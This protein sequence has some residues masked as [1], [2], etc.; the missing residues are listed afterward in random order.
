MSAV[1]REVYDMK[2]DIYRTFFKS[3][4][5]LLEVIEFL[6]DATMIID[7]EG[8]VVMWN[9]AME[10]LTGVKSAQITGKGNYEHSIPFYG[11]RRPTL[12]DIALKSYPEIEKTYISLRRNRDTLYGEIRVPGFRDGGTYLWGI[13][14]PLYSSS[15]EIIGAIESI[16]DITG[17]KESHA[18]IARQDEELLKADEMLKLSEEKFSKAFRSSPMIISIST[19]AD[20]RYI[21]VSDSFYEETGYSRDEVIGH[22]AF[23]INI[24]VDLS[25][26]DRI[27]SEM[28]EKGRVRELEIRFRSKDGGIRTKLFSAEIISLG[29]VPCLLAVNA[30]ITERK[31]AME[32][33]EKQKLELEAVNSELTRTIRSMEETHIRLMETQR[34]LV[35]SN[36]RL[37]FSE[38]KFSKTVH[39]GPVIITLSRLAD[40][41]Y[42][43]VSEYFLKLTGYSRD[44]VVGHSSLDLNIWDDIA[45]RELVIEH[46]RRDGVVKEVD[47][48][49][50]AKDGRVFI[51]RYS[52]EIVSIAGEP[53]L[54][55]VAV[56][57]TERLKAEKEKAAVEEQLL[58]SQKMETVGRLAGGI[59]HDFN[60]LLT[61]IMGHV[62]LS[63]MKIG[64]E[65]PLRE[66]LEVI[67]RASET[68]ADLTKRILAFSRKQVIEPKLI[69][70]DE[71]IDHMEMLL[72]RLIG[73]NVTLET[74][75]GAKMADIMADP[76]HMEQVLVNLA[77]N[78]RDAMPGG[79]RLTLE[80]ANV[81]L[82][83]HYCRKHP[84]ALPGEYV[85]LSV[86]DTGTGMSEEVKKHLFEP[87]F[88][89]KP[90][91]QGT[92]LGL[93]MV[94]GVV[95]QN[96]GTIEVYSVEGKG[97]SFKMY[98][99][100]AGTADGAEAG[101]CGEESC[102]T[103]NET[104]L[105]VEDNPMVLGFAENVLEQ[106]GYRVFSAVRGE[107]M[108]A[109]DDSVINS[110]DI[111]IT[112]VILPGINGSDLAEEIKKRNPGIRVLY[113]SGYTEDFAVK[114]EIR[115]NGME[116]IGK[117]YS[118]HTL[119]RRI[120]DMLG[121]G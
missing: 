100:L 1:M 33:I 7:T 56:D 18:R 74:V 80:T 22:T 43:E 94:Y 69:N 57:I 13:A 20:G 61:A 88:T 2:K 97:T 81:H 59:A 42:V 66:H 113:T 96:G 109:M 71:V 27:L 95:R 4:D 24:W 101:S 9:H 25:D 55:S 102:L 46:L 93:S 3:E 52:A 11:E 31:K 32:I 89:T 49:F 119:L 48:R 58:Q 108:L 90:R 40:G 112:D 38:E 28:K 114:H 50:R 51:M 19:V 78:S 14:K 73:E 76:G 75:H 62:E 36:E 63:M 85:M 15:G 83:S 79:G 111:L 35:A 68:A 41:V 29:G 53:H 8:R 77:V 34:E 39:L 60:N 115:R 107:E 17:L 10:E 118:A 103:G 87:F 67:L 104:V 30:D 6:P 45:D 106:A 12:A 98:F 84:H 110:A 105:L 86:S 120:R 65:S 5:E 21:D 26:R 91:G 16:R 99:P 23:E 82:D 64:E 117:P 44:E 116:F 54:V 47:I 72:T 37:R 92:G 70:L 121:A